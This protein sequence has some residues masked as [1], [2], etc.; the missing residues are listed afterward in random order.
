MW[1]DEVRDEL[2]VVVGYGA[3]PP[4]WEYVVGNGVMGLRKIFRGT[5]IDRSLGFVDMHLIGH[6]LL[7]RTGPAPAAFL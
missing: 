2:V 3:P 7:S 5:C 6:M 1:V 4:P